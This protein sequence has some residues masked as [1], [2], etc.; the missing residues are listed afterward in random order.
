LLNVPPD[1]VG[2]IHPADSVRLVEFRKERETVFANNLLQTA[3]VT[4]S[5]VRGNALQYAAANVQDD[6][7]D[8]YWTVDDATTQASI[9]V[10]FKE[11]Q[12][13]NRLLLQEYIPLGQRVAKFNVEVWDETAGAWKL[14][15]E[16]TTIGYKRILRFPAVSAERIRINILHSLACPVLSTVSAYKAAE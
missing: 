2:R 9:E 10:K 7:F 3:A 1:R 15:T 8:T 6:D 13:F 5:A 16:A 4:A 12:T 11:R 14:L